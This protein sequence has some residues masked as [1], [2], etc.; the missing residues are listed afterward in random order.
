[1]LTSVLLDHWFRRNLISELQSNLDV[2]AALIVSQVPDGFFLHRDAPRLQELAHALNKA[3]GCRV[4]FIAPDGIVLGESALDN[5]GRVGM[6]NHSNRPEVMAA[7]RGQAGHATHLSQTLGQTFLYAAFP[8]TEKGNLTG[9]VRVSVSLSDVQAKIDRINRRIVVVAAGVVLG[10]I[11]LALGLARSLSGP[12]AEMSRVAER[13][14]EGRYETRVTSFP[15]DEHGGLG[16][17]LN[18]LAERVQ[19]KVQE[20]VREK[21]RLSTILETMTEAVAAVDGQGRVIVVNPSLCRLFGID[22]ESARGRKFLEVLRHNELNALLQNALSDQRERT[23][24]VR[25]FSPDE[26]HFEAL[27]APLHEEGVFAGVLL[28][29]HDISRI[30]RLEQVRRDFVANVSHELRTPLALIKGFAETLRMGGMDDKKNRKEFLEKI[31]RHADRMTSLV[32]DLLDLTAIESGQ[33]ALQSEP[34][35][36]SELLREL[37]DSLKPMAFRKEIDLVGTFDGP[38][39]LVPGDRF[40]LRQVFVNLIENALKF[41]PE[42][43]TVTIGIDLQNRFATVLVKDTGIGI[44]APDLPRIFERFYRVDKARSRELGGTGL[45]LSIVKHIVEAHG[46]TVSVESAPG[47]GSAFAVS[48]PRF[49]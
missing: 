29:L 1:M 15:P 3:S 11:A 25:T 35:N 16:R 9:I 20:L 39:P 36:L 30:R 10:A 24:E 47:N 8:V 38:A 32:A 33:R 31:E 26:R 6:Q 21:A 5:A 34:V 48:L 22:P 14:I 27:V 49:L 28:V 46:G 19:T 7:M 18:A 17:T 13:L 40:Q 37:I 23:A 43:G 42:R 44:P 4:T 45:G 12:V 2:Q 41:T